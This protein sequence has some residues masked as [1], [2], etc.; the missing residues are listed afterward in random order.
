MGL[1]ITAFAQH[2]PSDEDRGT[3]AYINPDFPGQADDVKEGYY[4]SCGDS[5]Y[6]RAGSYSGYNEWRRWLAGLV[7]TTPE[8]VWGDKPQIPFYELIDFA[9]NEG[10]IGPAVSA[11]LRDDFLN[12]LEKARND[13]TAK[14]EP[15]Y[16]QKYICWLNAFTIAAQDGMVMFR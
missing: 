5:L 8:K 7:G 4:V 1:D 16:F 9:D 15:Y 10:T 6:F 13:E 14:N 2:Y 12:N 3:F 11:K